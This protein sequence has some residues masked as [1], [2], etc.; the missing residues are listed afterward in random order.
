MEREQEEMEEEE[1]KLVDETSALLLKR[2]KEEKLRQKAYIHRVG[3]AES[4][5]Y[6]KRKIATKWLNYFAINKDKSFVP[7]SRRYESKKGKQKTVV[8][9][10]Q[11]EVKSDSD[12]IDPRVDNI[13]KLKKNLP[14]T[15]NDKKFY[16]EVSSLI[17]HGY[18]QKKH[19]IGK[20]KKYP[21]SSFIDINKLNMD[22]EN[23]FPEYGEDLEK[24]LTNDDIQYLDR[25]DTDFFNYYMNNVRSFVGIKLGKKD[26]T[27]RTISYEER[28]LS[29]ELKVM[30]LACKLC[31]LKTQYRLV[32]YHHIANKIRSFIHEEE[33]LSGNPTAHY[34]KADPKYMP[35][36][37]IDPNVSA[38][39]R[40]RI[41]RMNARYDKRKYT[42]EGDMKNLFNKF[43]DLNNIMYIF[44]NITNP[45]NDELE[46]KQHKEQIEE[47]KME[48]E[49][50]DIKY[51][52]PNPTYFDWFE[53]GVPITPVP[54]K[55]EDCFT[56]E[57]HKAYRT[58]WNL[59][60]GKQPIKLKNPHIVATKDY[61]RGNW[62]RSLRDENVELGIPVN[63]AGYENERVKLVVNSALKSIKPK[64]LT[65]IQIAMQKR[66][67]RRDG[68]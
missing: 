22:R 67:A 52:R 64:A 55:I 18:F 7:N 9:D 13:K 63:V 65:P 66:D 53:V 47:R 54:E 32:K 39:E 25:V 33:I 44:K 50:K 43:N 16:P 15:Y 31:K 34:S 37:K 4:K 60:K 21:L 46:N 68:T 45:L 36:Q 1:E 29:Y 42:V 49:L 8:H 56:V 41:V 61:E 12:D 2:A 35:E 14:L 24:H 48:M 30:F 51:Y 3:A 58:M 23:V 10:D 17:E 26:P 28:T 20:Y 38:Q 62:L 57:E 19:A 27:E 59:M 6:N 11:K 5:I 40:R